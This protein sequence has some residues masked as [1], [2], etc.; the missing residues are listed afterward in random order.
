M[1]VVAD[2]AQGHTEAAAVHG[3]HAAPSVRQYINIFIVLFI[4]T[5][6]EVGAS[7]LVNIGVPLWLQ[8]AIL[9]VLMI[10]KGA[11][12]VMY[13][14]HLKFDSRWFAF[15]FTAGMILATFGLIVL[16]ILFDYHRGQ[17]I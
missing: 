2:H 7:F 4:V 17:V 12:V 16:M 6:V 9:I 13:Y 1:H 14:M 5:A 8:V 15:F 3:A 11:L 10:I